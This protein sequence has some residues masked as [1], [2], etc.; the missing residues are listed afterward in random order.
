MSFMSQRMHLIHAPENCI[1]LQKRIAQT[2]TCV[3]HIQVT[4][5]NSC[6][7]TSHMQ[8]QTEITHTCTRTSHNV[9]HIAHTVAYA[10]IL[11]TYTEQHTYNH[12]RIQI[13]HMPLITTYAITWSWT[14]HTNIKRQPEHLEMHSVWSHYCIIRHLTPVHSVT[15]CG[16][17]K[18]VCCDMWCVGCV[19]GIRTDSSEM[20]VFGCETAY[21]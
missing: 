3:N 20:A 10:Y 8:S 6:T 5:Q 9:S 2:V 21:Y 18:H 1:R 14:S 19:L 4:W 7:Y 17:W 16:N 15:E 11:H 13:T 12:I